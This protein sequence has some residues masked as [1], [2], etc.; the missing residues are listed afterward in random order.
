MP[1]TMAACSGVLR[2]FAIRAISSTASAYTQLL[3]AA[4]VDGLQ[5]RGYDKKIAYRLVLRDAETGVELQSVPVVIDRAFT[6]DF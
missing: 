5:D 2:S 3:E 6:D 1:T 4:T